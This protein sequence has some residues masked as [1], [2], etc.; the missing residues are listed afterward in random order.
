MGQSRNDERAREECTG[1]KN[2][3]TVGA[4]KN[5]EK[6]K[7]KGEMQGLRGGRKAAA[8]F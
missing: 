5:K 8:Y 6:Q 1:K 7:I 4:G 2:K 3:G